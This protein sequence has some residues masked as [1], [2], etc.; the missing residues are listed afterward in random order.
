MECSQSFA[1]VALTAV[2]GRLAY[3]TA[4]KW[5]RTKTLRELYIAKA[6]EVQNLDIVCETAFNDGVETSVETNLKKGAIG[7]AVR[8]KGQFRNYL[9]QQGKA[10][11][12]CPVRNEANR[13]VVRKHLYDVCSDHGLI[14]RHINDHLDVATELVF[15]PSQDQLIALAIPHTVLSKTRL[16]VSEDLGGPRVAIA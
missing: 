6:A 8:H 16:Q 14:A 13:L 5:W 3:H 15:I 11:F 1:A 7:L 9:V 12:G 10:K 2:A 4:L